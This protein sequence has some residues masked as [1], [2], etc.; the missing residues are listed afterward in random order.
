[1]IPEAAGRGRHR[2][3]PDRITTPSRAA[4]GE[5]QRTQY[6][7]RWRST[8]VNRRP[9]IEKPTGRATTERYHAVDRAEIVDCA[10]TFDDKVAHL[11]RLAGKAQQI[12]H[13][14]AG[15]LVI[16]EL[17]HG[18]IDAHVV[19]DIAPEGCVHRAKPAVAG[20]LLSLTCLGQR[21]AEQAMVEPARRDIFRDHFR[22]QCVR[23]KALRAES[24]PGCRPARAVC[25]FERRVCASSSTGAEFTT[26]ASSICWEKKIPTGVRMTSD[27]R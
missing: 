22:Q 8:S 24:D 11:P 3:C 17:R 1:M 10:D 25:R 14:R 20:V 21:D 18:D 19:V 6:T 5:S 9:E 15:G 27:R 12:G 4:A 26:I 7:N 2:C 16:D 13:G 23:A